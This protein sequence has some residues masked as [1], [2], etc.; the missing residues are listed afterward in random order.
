MG[1]ETHWSG[2]PFAAFLMTLLI[3]AGSATNLAASEGDVRAVVERLNTTL[4]DV[5]QSADTLGYQGRYEKLDP[6]LRS[7]FDFGFMAKIAV[8][9]TWNKLDETERGELVERFS[10]MSIATF[11]S[12]FDGYSG[13]RF[14]IFGEEPGPRGTIVVDDRIIRPEKPSVGLNFVLKAETDNA[15]ADSWRIIDVMLDG[16][17][18]EL[19]RQ[20]AEFSA[21]LK[22]GGYDDLI[23]ALDERIADLGSNG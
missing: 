16:K 3:I 21:V 1:R 2:G 9:R 14:E 15:Q 5:M 18:S 7:S 23:T 8:G 17:F 12:R 13:E 4:L 19:A 11:A 22:N 20:R 6:V 10:Q